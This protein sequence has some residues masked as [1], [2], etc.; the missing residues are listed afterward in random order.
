MCEK[1]PPNT[2]IL[3][4]FV[5]FVSFLVGMERPVQRSPM[6]KLEELEEWVDSAIEKVGKIEV[7]MQ[8]GANTNVYRIPFPEF[9][10]ENIDHWSAKA[11]LYFDMEG[12][13]GDGH[14]IDIASYHLGETVYGWHGK[15]MAKH[16]YG[17]TWAEYVS[18]LKQ[19][20]EETL[21]APIVKLLH[22]RQKPNT[23]L[24][25]FNDE[26]DSIV[27]ALSLK[28]EHVLEAYLESLHPD[29][30]CIVKI[31]QPTSLEEARSWARS[32]E[33]SRVRG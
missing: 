18:A 28:Q 21:E 25:E 10:R 3:L 8:L 11:E 7:G 15:I 17:L 12:V 1:P 2:H 16:G 30:G 14:K 19:E 32:I 31:Y 22:L 4:R 29:I 5:W 26:F 13:R 33:L 20:Y 24:K 27:A 9:H 6:Q 23:P